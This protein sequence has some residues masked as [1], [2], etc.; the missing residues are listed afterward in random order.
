MNAPAKLAITLLM[1]CTHFV[2]AS[3]TEDFLNKLK[4]HYKDTLHINA[5][6]LNH[7]FLNKRYRGKNYWDFNMPNR[8]MSIR[9]VEIDL[10]RKHYYDNDILYFP[11]GLLYDRVQFQNDTEG[12]F[13]EKSGV[14]LGKAIIKQDMNRFDAVASYLVMKLDFM[15]VRPLLEEEEEEEEEVAKQ[16]EIKNIKEANTT[17]VTHSLPDGKTVEYLFNNQPFQLKSVKHSPLNGY[18]EYKDY[19]TTRGINYARVVHQH[20]NGATVPQYVTYNDSFNVIK[21]VDPNHFV[22]PKGYD[23]ELVRGDGILFATKLSKDLHL[24]TDSGGRLNSVLKINGDKITAFGASNNKE[25]AEQILKF[26]E[27]YFPNKKLDSV[28]VSHPHAD[29]ISGLSTYAKEGVTILADQYTISAIKANEP[30]KKEIDSVKFKPINN[31]QTIDGTTFYVLETMRSKRQSFV[32]FKE[33]GVVFQSDF[34]HIPFDGY[35]PEV[36]PNYT[37]TFIDLLRDK[38]LNLKRII[39]N[40]GHNNITIEMMDEAYNALM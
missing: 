22:L 23:T 8:A 4:S 15:A 24:I 30:F 18:F 14:F 35:I 38:Q 20:Y 19:K 5:F 12:Y 32:Y 39:S 13:Y 31:E 2:Y 26:I 3:D 29:E 28:H 36:I 6:S 27:N 25:L 9:T 33:A 1:L 11:G 17:L 7:H 10:E 37:R 40:Y 16:V 21:Q 34:L